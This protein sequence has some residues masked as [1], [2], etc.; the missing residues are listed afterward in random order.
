MKPNLPASVSSPEELT[1][2]ILETREYAKW[3]RQ[4]ANASSQKVRYQVSQPELSNDASIVIRQWLTAQESTVAA[5]D[6]LP[7][8]LEAIKKTAPTMSITL[9]APV[10]A[11]VK[12]ELVD[13]CRTN[14]HAEMLVGFSFNATILGGMVV[15]IGSR[16]YDWSHRRAILTNRDKFAGVLANV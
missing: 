9:A 16:I 4:Y 3:Y 2:L 5:V 1:R 12:K 7:E 14:L 15:R 13:W 10:T 11:E 8:A 6:A